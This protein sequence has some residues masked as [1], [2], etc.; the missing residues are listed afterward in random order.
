MAS[1]WLQGTKLNMV[2]KLCLDDRKKA[3]KVAKPFQNIRI[4]R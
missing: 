1:C 2:A 3:E 4:L